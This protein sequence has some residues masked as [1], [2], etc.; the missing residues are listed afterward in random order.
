MTTIELEEL[1]IAKQA[2]ERYLNDIRERES[3]LAKEISEANNLANDDI[4]VMDDVTSEEVNYVLGHSAGFVD[5]FKSAMDT[6]IME[7]AREYRDVPISS[8][9]LYMMAELGKVE[10]RARIKDH[11]SKA[12]AEKSGWRQKWSSRAMVWMKEVQ[13]D[14]E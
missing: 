8:D 7:L 2:A 13:E 3:A 14:E 4:F 12:I 6:I 1:K 10:E 9:E 11:R 5:G